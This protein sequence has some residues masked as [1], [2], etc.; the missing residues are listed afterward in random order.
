MVMTVKCPTC[1][2][3]TAWEENRFRPFCSER[4]KLI[5]FS[6]WLDQK[7]AIEVFDPEDDDQKSN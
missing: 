3:E 5:D 6:K 2:K 1:K 4:C 7:Y